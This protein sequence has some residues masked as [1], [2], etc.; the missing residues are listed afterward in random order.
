MKY[1]KIYGIGLIFIVA[2][3]IITAV[4]YSG[5]LTPT[6][7]VKARAID[8][9][10]TPESISSLSNA[11]N[12]FSFNIYQYIVNDTDENVFFSPYSIF[13]ALAMT[14][15]GARGDT[16]EQMKNQ[17]RAVESRESF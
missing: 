3:I 8:I 17:N 12:N 7:I 13:V 6:N 11:I 4:F 15:E 2:I 10:A 1:K 5:L 16:A 14:Y 9:Y